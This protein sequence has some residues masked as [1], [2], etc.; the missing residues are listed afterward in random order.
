MV[1]LKPWGTYQFYITYTVMYKVHN[2][3]APAIRVVESFYWMDNFNVPGG[4]ARNSSELPM[5]ERGVDIDCTV[6]VRTS[7]INDVPQRYDCGVDERAFT[8]SN[9]R[10][11]VGCHV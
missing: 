2:P 11:V 4:A 1:N 6:S 9:E 8:S 10:S 7:S 5:H 3:A